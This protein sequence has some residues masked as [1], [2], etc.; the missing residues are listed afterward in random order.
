MV[1][2]E[3]VCVRDPRGMNVAGRVVSEWDNTSS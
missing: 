2:K 1:G 3:I